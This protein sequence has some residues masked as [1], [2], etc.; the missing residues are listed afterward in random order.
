MCVYT[1]PIDGC[2]NE[3][4]ALFFCVRFI[5]S[6]IS[7]IWQA[8]ILVLPV[9]IKAVILNELLKDMQRAVRTLIFSETPIAAAFL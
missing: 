9:D 5:S 2:M 1:L 6:S 8:V 3:P 4:V 7:Y